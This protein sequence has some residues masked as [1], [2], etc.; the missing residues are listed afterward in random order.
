FLAPRNATEEALAEIWC[1]VLAVARVSVNDSF[2][3]LGG[4][5]LL[6]TKAVAR[7]KEHFKVEF[8]LKALFD[9]HTI[10]EIGEYIDG[11]KWALESREKQDA[12]GSDER[13]EEG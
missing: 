5:S 9:L 8:P 1:E 3:E 11:L 10:A 6:A 12:Q 7:L 4:H 13:R 2:F